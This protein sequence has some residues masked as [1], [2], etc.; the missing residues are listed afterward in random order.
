MANIF[1]ALLFT[2]SP[3]EIPPDAWNCRNQIEVWCTTDS[4]AAAN[5]DET[6]PLDIWASRDGKLS[7]CAYSGCWETTTIVEDA[8]GR[9]VWAAD[10]VAFRGSRGGAGADITLMIIEKDG[11]G[12]VR[13]GGFATPLLCARA[14]PD[15]RP[16]D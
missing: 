13:A 11:V 14:A 8:N 16:Q 10:N 15:S 6:T 9:L 12:F 5:E 7:V 2:A 4:C 3:A 1:L